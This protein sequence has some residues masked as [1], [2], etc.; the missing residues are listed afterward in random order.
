MVV[1]TG[2]TR[3]GRKATL[4]GR[5]AT[6]VTP[7]SRGDVTVGGFDWLVAARPAK[8]QTVEAFIERMKGLVWCNHVKRCKGRRHHELH[9]ADQTLAQAVVRAL[10]YVGSSSCTLVSACLQREQ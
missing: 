8:R 1:W 2:F 6:R 9:P 10:I 3:S 7:S 5:Q 4:C